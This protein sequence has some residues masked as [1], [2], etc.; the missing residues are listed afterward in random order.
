[1]NDSLSKALALLPE[2]LRNLEGKENWR[3]DALTILQAALNV[4]THYERQEITDRA[5]YLEGLEML[6]DG[7]QKCQSATAGEKKPG[8][9]MTARGRF[10]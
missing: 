2:I 5:A 9:D 3:A 1:M 10:A 6:V 7:V 4:D 8:Q